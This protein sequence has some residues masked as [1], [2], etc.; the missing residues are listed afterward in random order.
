[1][2][3][4]ESRKEAVSRRIAAAASGYLAPPPVEF[5]VIGRAEHRTED[6]PVASDVALVA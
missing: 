1:M 4:E 3:R 6:R 2:H 5:I